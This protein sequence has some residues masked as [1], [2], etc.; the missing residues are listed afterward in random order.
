MGMERK[1]KRG[2]KVNKKELE[3]VVKLPATKRY[4]YFIKKVADFKEVWGLYNDGWAT[5]EDD[6]ENIL[7]PFWPNKEFS[8]FCAIGEWKN[9]VPEKIDLYEFIDE[10]LPGI[11]Q[12]KYKP[13]IF[14]NNNDSAVIEVDILLRDLNNELENY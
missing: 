6:N 3:F 8:Q 11:K 4:E 12:D 10:W 14:C 5:T 2:S 13:A 1:R 7:I 9:Y